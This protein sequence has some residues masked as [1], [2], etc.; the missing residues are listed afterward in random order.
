MEFIKELCSQMIPVIIVFLLVL[1][2][3]IID[4]WYD[5]YKFFKDWNS[6][7]D[8]EE[9]KRVERWDKINNDYTSNDSKTKTD[10]NYKQTGL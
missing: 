8:R 4:A 9:K 10:G 1:V 5:S 2:Y 6:W 3:I 7:M